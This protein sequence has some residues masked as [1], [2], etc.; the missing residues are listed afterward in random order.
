MAEH[1]DTE[2]LSRLLDKPEGDA[3]ATEHLDECRT[4]ARELEQLRRMRMALSGMGE[5]EPP[6][7]EWSRIEEGLRE[8]GVG[9]ETDRSSGQADGRESWALGGSSWYGGWPARAA[10]AILV[11]GVGVA[12]GLQVDM[13]SGMLADEGQ[14]DG[15]AT[16]TTRLAADQGTAGQEAAAGSDLGGIL[17]SAGFGQSVNPVE[18]PVTAAEELARLDALARAV[19]ERL[20]SDPADPEL[21]DLLFQ[22]ADRQESLTREFGQAAHLVSL[23][24]R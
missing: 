17:T 19:R 8:A 18:D 4:C 5:Q 24:Y 21:N 3:A 15:A 12:A 16:E 14:G 20:R 13:G 7:G 2:R 23:D 10:A 22:I 1:L 11:F 9:A 6:A